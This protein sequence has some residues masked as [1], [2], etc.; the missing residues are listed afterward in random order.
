MTY[1]DGF[2]IAVPKD[3]LDAYK[4]MARKGCKIWMEHGAL[5]YAECVADDVPHG[6][7]TDF[8]RAVKCKED[9]TVIFAYIVYKSRASRDA[10]LKKVMADPRLHMDPKDMPF[11]GKRMFWGGFKTVVESK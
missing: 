4:K 7:S 8:Y 3:K 2:V 6:K 9:E 10:V 11:D 1:T 5:H